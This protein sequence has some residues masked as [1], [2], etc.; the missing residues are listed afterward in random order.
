M[1]TGRAPVRERDFD[2]VGG[3]HH[4]VIGQDVAIR[5]DDDA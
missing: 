4:M 2:L 3:L 1:R 5:A